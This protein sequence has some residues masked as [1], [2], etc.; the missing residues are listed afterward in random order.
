MKS[1]KYSYVIR[2]K[3]DDNWKEITLEEFNALTLEDANRMP[4]IQG[5]KVIITNYFNTFWGRIMGAR[6]FRVF[7]VLSQFA[8]GN[9]DYSY[10]SWDTLAEICGMSKNTVKAAVRT[11]E[12]LGFVLQV[13]V[14]NKRGENE[15]NIFLLRKTTP[16]LSIEQY[17]S[18]PPKMQ[19]SHRVYLEN[20]EKSERVVLS[21]APT[22]PAPKKPVRKRF[23]FSR[24]KIDSPQQTPIAV[25]SGDNL[26]QID[27]SN[28][29]SPVPSF[30]VGQQQVG[31]GQNLTPG[32]GQ[33]LTPKHYSS[34]STTKLNQ[35]KESFTFNA[36]A[37]F[38]EC[39]QV[40]GTL[41]FRTWVEKLEVQGYDEDRNVLT[42]R[43]EHPMQQDWVNTRYTKVMSKIL[44]DIFNLT[45]AAVSV[46]LA[47]SRD[48]WAI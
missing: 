38:D 28:S 26:S 2:T 18:L 27:G 40:L 16:F 41:S 39:K 45:D 21:N 14:F 1:N 35:L 7:L 19:E 46:T 34:S 15:N 37:F 22:Y 47:P 12:D 23:F 25:E 8:Y 24:S 10:P 43:A 33:E 20:I 36:D 32:T 48:R 3:S 17:E 4:E 42:L 9:K 30:D 11:L 5:N 13:Q 31:V 6:N 29:D 44:R